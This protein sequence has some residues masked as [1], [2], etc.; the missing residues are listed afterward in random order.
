MPDFT[1]I[2]QELILKCA[3][4]HEVLSNKIRRGYGS[5]VGFGSQEEFT[6]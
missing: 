6:K 4:E 1:T 3:R 2:D 5:I